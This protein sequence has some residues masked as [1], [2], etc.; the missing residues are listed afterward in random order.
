MAAQWKAVKQILLSHDPRRIGALISVKRG[1]AL[2]SSYYINPPVAPQT[3]YL[4]RREFLHTFAFGTAHGSAE[5][6]YEGLLSH[7]EQNDYDR[8]ISGHEWELGQGNV[9]DRDMKPNLRLIFFDE[10][11]WLKIKLMAAKISG[12]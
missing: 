4:S 5:P 7:L 8:Q 2:R 9:R 1:V 10:G 11:G 12:D 6:L 3:E